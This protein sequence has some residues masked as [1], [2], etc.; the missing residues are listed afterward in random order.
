MKAPF[1]ERGFYSRISRFLV[2][3][4]LSGAAP[5][6]SSLHS[7]PPFTKFH[8][9]RRRLRPAPNAFFDQCP[10]IFYPNPLTFGFPTLRV[11]PHS[12]RILL[13]SFC[14]LVQKG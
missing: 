12:T 13:Y 14:E 1:D 10:P 4:S 2:R 8:L 5:F 3:A 7:S 11:F 6:T 9:T